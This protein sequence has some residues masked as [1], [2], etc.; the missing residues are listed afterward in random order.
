MAQWLSDNAWW[1]IVAS[2]VMLLGGIVV[3]FVLAIFMPAGHFMRPRL[4]TD[5]ASRHP[6]LRILAQVV[7][8]V[9]GAVLFV[10]GFV[11]AVPMVPGPGLL[12]ILLG[13]S[14][15]DVP[16]KRALT[17]YIVS[18]PLVLRPINALRARWNR[19]PIQLP[20]DHRQTQCKRRSR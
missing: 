17:R 16:G 6:V 13:I 5:L 12:F 18:R 15:M 7:K 10:A 9:A 3:S 2:T 4:R 20:H 1:L 8:N 11:M 19:P 14:L